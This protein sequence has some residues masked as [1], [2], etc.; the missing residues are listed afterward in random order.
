MSSFDANIKA[1]TVPTLSSTATAA[2]IATFNA[3]FVKN[4]VD[5]GNSLLSSYI[6]LKETDFFAIGELPEIWQQ[7]F[8]SDV[9]NYQRFNE[10]P[11][12]NRPTISYA[13]IENA[14]DQLNALQVPTE[15]TL[16]P[17]SG[18]TPN[19]EVSPPTVVLPD[20]PDTTLPAPPSGE[21]TVVDPAL[22]ATPTY[23]LPDV[24]TFEDLQLPAAP[25]LAVPSFDEVAPAFNLAP[26]TQQFSYVDPG[27]A[28]ALRDELVVKLLNDLRYGSYGIEP[29]DEAALWYRARDRAASLAKREVQ[30]ITRRA[31]ATSFP[32]PQGALYDA[33]EM[34]EQKHTNDLAE[35]NREIALKR[36]D[37]YVEGRK[38]TFQ[39][40][41]QYERMEQDLYNATQ[42]RALNY[43]KAVVEMGILVYRASVDQFNAQ[44]QAYAIRAQVFSE[45]VRAELAKAQIY[46][47]QVEAESVRV[48]FNR[49]KI[50]QYLA[51]LKAIDTVVDLYK[52]ELQAVTIQMQVQ[53]QKIDVFKAQLQT[54]SER[55][56]AKEAEY[57]IYL[58]ATRGELAKVDV[59]KAQIDAYNAT[60]SGVETQ[61]RVR[62]QSNESLLQ[63]Y[64]TATAAYASKM[65]ALKRLIDGRLEEARLKGIIYT[66][67]IDAY[68]AIVQSSASAQNALLD[69][70]RLQQNYL[71]EQNRSAQENVRFKLKQLEDSVNLQSNVN[72]YGIDFIRA[73]LA[74]ATSGLNSLGVK[75]E[76]G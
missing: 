48:D 55:L 2:D 13:D 21:P 64:R 65:E 7:W 58:A 73:A 75:T 44:M 72:R 24:P 56:R 37:M 41:Q 74:G 8:S 39:Q 1:I 5:T 15:P 71:V 76:E 69:W 66:H 59:Y 57:N 61:A 54:Y 11:D 26:P 23:T 17:V 40:V 30:E 31:A 20:Q 3:T 43:A 52:S 63:Q 10:R 45:R 33:L 29:A 12:T 4:I 62:L 14:L 6:D 49:A 19:L 32:M 46:K 34:A 18:D 36:A 51:Q 50:D 67:D 60:L 53:Q 25:A 42:E 68:R 16:S 70:G 9:P 38:F 28:S 47:T 27:Y 22:P 35:V